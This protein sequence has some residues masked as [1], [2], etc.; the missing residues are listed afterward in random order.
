MAVKHW[1]RALLRRYGF[2][3]V[4]YNVAQNSD[5]QTAKVLENFGTNLVFDV[6]ANVGQFAKGLISAGYSGRVISFEPQSVEYDELA[7]NAAR[8][9]QWTCHSRCAVGAQSGQAELNIAGNSL[10]SSVLPMLPSHV[11]GAPESAYVDTQSVSVVALD[12]VYQSYVS[13]DSRIALKID[14]QG[15]EWEVLQGAESMLPRVDVV[16]CELSLTPLYDGQRL[17]R[18]LI[19]HMAERGF[20]LFVIQRGFTNPD[21]GK[22]LQVDAVFVR[23]SLV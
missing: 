8:F 10:S 7:A 14:T 4:A 6:G 20:E 3:V 15:F 11:Q 5:L 18:D 16:L 1:I 21:T 2:D 9:E 12:E 17:W 19:D 23:A 22:T 13:G